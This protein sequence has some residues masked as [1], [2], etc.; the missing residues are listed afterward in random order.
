MSA[1]D[2]R[3]EEILAEYFRIK[4][5]FGNIPIQDYIAVRDASIREL[6]SSVSL[7]CPEFPV[8]EATAMKETLP[9]A[10]IYEHVASTQTGTD[11]LHVPAPQVQTP[12]P[13]QEEKL[14]PMDVLAMMKD[15]WND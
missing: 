3:A 15:T 11:S 13:A 1:V 12:A 9:H 4:G 2:R 8:Q 7:H 6:E 10:P 5:K 14:S